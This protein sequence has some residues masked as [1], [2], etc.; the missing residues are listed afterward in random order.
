MRTPDARTAGTLDRSLRDAS[1]R[2]PVPV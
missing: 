1:P 2:A